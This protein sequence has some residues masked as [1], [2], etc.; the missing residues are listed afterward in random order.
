MKDRANNL[1][2]DAY[3]EVQM[4]ST[5]TDRRLRIE[6]AQILTQN[7]LKRMGLL[8]GIYLFS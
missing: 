2:L 4:N 6:H 5:D 3:E 8:G 7:D 1:I